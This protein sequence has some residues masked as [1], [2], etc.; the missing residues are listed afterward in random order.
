M[1]KVSQFRV[2]KSPFVERIF[3]QLEDKS[4]KIWAVSQDSALD[5]QR[6]AKEY[7]I[8][9]PILIDEYPY[10][11]SRAYSVKYVPTLYLISADSRI[12]ISS[13]GFSKADFLAI[14]KSLAESSRLSPPALFQPHERVPE[15]KPG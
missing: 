12:Q 3:K 4:V 7:G 11:I 6:F 9:F 15:Y 2:S 13:E 10:E 14:S 8:T 5:S 1:I